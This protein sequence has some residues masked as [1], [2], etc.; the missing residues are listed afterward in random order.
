MKKAFSIRKFRFLTVLAFLYSLNLFNQSELILPLLFFCTAFAFVPGGRLSILKMP[1][2]GNLI[3][4]LLFALSYIGIATLYNSYSFLYCIKRAIYPLIAYWIGYIVVERTAQSSLKASGLVFALTSGMSLY[5]FLNYWKRLSLGVAGTYRTSVDFWTGAELAPTFENTLFIFLVALT[6]FFLVHSKTK[7]RYIGLLAIGISYVI[8]LSTASRSA[9]AIS[10]VSIALFEVLYLIYKKNSKG[11]KTKG[12]LIIL[13]GICAVLF[14]YQM[15]MFGIQSKILASELVTR[16]T[17]T[18]VDSLIDMSQR[19]IRYHK[20]F[21]NFWTHL[22]GNIDL[23]DLGSAH[24]TWLDIFR[25]SGI[26]PMVLFVIFTVRIFNSLR[27]LW[28]GG[29]FFDYETF[30]GISIIVGSNLLFF[31]ESIIALNISY[32]W[33]YLIVC[34]MIDSKVE[35]VRRKIV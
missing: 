35:F 28:E 15:N 6:F 26:L 3:I 23:G 31:V 8:G 33:A 29:Y 1:V 14:M 7:K 16:M 12:I 9:I 25:V 11:N 2:N 24:N 27:I 22:L 18:S 17:T 32:F 5:G 13:V 34:G 4:L 20:I 30:P 21:S 10:L 19:S